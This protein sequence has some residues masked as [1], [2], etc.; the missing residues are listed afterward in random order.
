MDKIVMRVVEKESESLNITFDIVETKF[1][2]KRI[3]FKFEGKALDLEHFLVC[4]RQIRDKL[5]KHPRYDGWDLSAKN[6]ESGQLE[7]LCDGSLF[8]N[9][10]DTNGYEFILHMESKA[11]EL[12]FQ[13]LWA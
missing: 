4:Y 13:A 10:K 3:N 1:N 12:I 7:C 8:F 6:N 11:T 9:D 5:N 2:S